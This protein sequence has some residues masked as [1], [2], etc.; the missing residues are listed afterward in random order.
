MALFHPHPTLSL[1]ERA[2]KSLSVSMVEKMDK[3]DGI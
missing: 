2:L 1:R 3:L